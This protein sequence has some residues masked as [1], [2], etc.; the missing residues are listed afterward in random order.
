MAKKM[1]TLDI[2]A[3]VLLIIGGLNWGLA[4]FNVNLVTMIF[5]KMPWLVN[6]VYGAVGVAAVYSIY[7]FVKN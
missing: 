6:I 5:G 4:I 7:S 2:V 1:E 3:I